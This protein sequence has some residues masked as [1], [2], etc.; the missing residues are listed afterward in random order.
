[1]KGRGEEGRRVREFVPCPKKKRKVGAY[2]HYHS[3]LH[4]FALASRIARNVIQVY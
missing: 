1:M 2:E 4:E 3:I